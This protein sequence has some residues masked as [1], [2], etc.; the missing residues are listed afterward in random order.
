MSKLKKGGRPPFFAIA[1]T[2]VLLVALAGLL[3]ISNQ[4]MGIAPSR[5]AIQLTP[6]FTGEYR[7]GD[8]PWQTYTPGNHIS[9]TQGTV[10]LRG[11]LHM[12]IK[13]EVLFVPQAPLLLYLD[14]LRCD[15]YFD[16]EKVYTSECEQP[17]L[18]AYGCAAI[19]GSMEGPATEDTQLQIVL[20]NPHRL[21]NENAVDE[22]I[23]QLYCGD[24]V[25]LRDQ[26]SRQEGTYRIISLVVVII[27]CALAGVSAFATVMRI[28][29]RD[30]LWLF[31]LI[32]LCAGGWIY[33]GAQN[34]TLWLSERILSTTG[35]ELCKMLYGL[36]L[37][38]LCARLFKGT[39][40]RLGQLAVGLLGVVV[41]VLILLP[42]I[43][44]LRIY[45]MKPWWMLAQGSA[46]LFLIGLCLYSAREE[47]GI[48]R[49]TLA[50]FCVLGVVAILD[51]LAAIFG[52]WPLGCVSQYSFFA[53]FLIAVVCALGVVPNNIHSTMR[54]KEL[55]KELTESRVATMISQIQPH[56]VSNTLGTIE[57]LCLS[58]PQT[59]ARIVHNFS[60]YL[61][62]NFRELDNPT[63]IRLREELNHLKCYTDIEKVRFPDMTIV[64]ELE[65]DDFLLPALTIQPLVENAIKHGLMGLDSG[66]TVRIRTYETPSHYVIE[67]TDDGVGFDTHAALEDR[68]HVGIRNIQGRLEAMCDGRL[69]IE[70][71][72]GKGT[73][74]TVKIPK[75]V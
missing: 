17:V 73:R 43:F 25:T 10:Y 13:D 7:I 57:Q 64:Y 52:W 44:D 60:V 23:R 31:S 69:T 55:E 2:A 65:A 34:R 16:G 68:E 61:R 58:D 66:G 18:G 41:S 1:V 30:V 35:S 45:D 67:V 24:T 4:D 27:A 47:K 63:P 6:V 56:F 12:Q 29:W 5:A 9:A 26:L 19:W 36:F 8:G 37:S 33:L 59:A 28:P 11:S 74:A 71:Q 21:G 40:R 54:A 20:E 49:F 38:V 42:G 72:P 39:A 32:A 15:V 48:K 14:H 62:G 75:E 53:L 46:A 70:S 3:L 51:M 22:F 50:P